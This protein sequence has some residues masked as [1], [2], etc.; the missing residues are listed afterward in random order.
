MFLLPPPLER[1]TEGRTDN[2]PIRLPDTK[3]EDFARLLSLFYPKDVKNGDLSTVE[4][5]TSVL[6]VSS[7]WGFDLHRQL[8]KERL[9][10]LASPFERILLSR[11]YD[12]KEWLVPALLDLST[13]DESLTLAEGWKLG[14]EDVILI[15]DIRQS[16]RGNG[17]VTITDRSIVNLI[18]A[19]L[20]SPS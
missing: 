18:H 19:K 15:S 4:E 16:I 11:Q 9:S 10:Q 6:A 3:S 7:R 12:V 1:E 13:R 2:D 5:W 14:M 8:S 17:R 20:N